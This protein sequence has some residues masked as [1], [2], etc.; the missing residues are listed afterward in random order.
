MISVNYPP[1]WYEQKYNDNCECGLPVEDCHT[2]HVTG[3]G[4][5]GRRCAEDCQGCIEVIEGDLEEAAME[6]ARGL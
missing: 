5:G 4:W 1:G 2:H 6:E 3:C